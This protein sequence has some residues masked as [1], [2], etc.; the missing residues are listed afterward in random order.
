M[1]RAL[2]IYQTHRED[3]APPQLGALKVEVRAHYDNLVAT[4]QRNELIA[5]DLAEMLCVR[6]E[7]LL[8]IAHQLDADAR[9]QIVG[10]ARYFIS[11]ADAVPDEQSCTGLDDDVDV[12][13]HMARSVGR[14]ELLISE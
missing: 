4:Q 13:N 14:L 7:G 5:I 9:S 8:A 1:S 6:L 12:F 10:A 11:S 3:L 2:E